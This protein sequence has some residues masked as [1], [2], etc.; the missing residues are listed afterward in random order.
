MPI[1]VYKGISYDIVVVM[2]GLAVNLINI[3]PYR[4][5]DRGKWLLQIMA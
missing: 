3:S 5:F 2:R 4:G 1:L